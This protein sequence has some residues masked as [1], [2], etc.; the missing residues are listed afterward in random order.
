MGGGGEGGGVYSSKMLRP[1][2]SKES[3][4]QQYL[5]ETRKEYAKCAYI[6]RIQTDRRN[7]YINIKN[8]HI[9]YVYIVEGEW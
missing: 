6:G 7:T 9:F 2:H 4:I 8:L 3:F 5:N 1:L